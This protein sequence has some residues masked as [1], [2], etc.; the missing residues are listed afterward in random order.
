[1]AQSN[2]N[3]RNVLRPLTIA[4][5]G[6]TM[7]MIFIVLALLL[8]PGEQIP[9]FDIAE[10]DW[11]TK[12]QWEVHGKIAVFDDMI[13]PGTE[14]QYQFIIR[15]ESEADLYFGFALREFVDTTVTTHRFMQYRLQMSGDY[16]GNND[17]WRYASEMAYQKLHILP[18]GE[19]LMTLEWRWPFENGTDGNDTLLGV[20]GGQLSIHFLV[21]AEVA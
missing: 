19:H 5:V 6:I 12:E 14:G 3:K 15:N 17:G 1:M 20:A 9:I 7:L 2:Q 11:I 21:L 18:G 13:Y 4:I 8:R 16:L 10:R